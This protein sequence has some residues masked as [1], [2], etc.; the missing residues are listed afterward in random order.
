M[1][2]HNSQSFSAQVV[3]ERGTAEAA[4]AVAEVFRR[5]GFETGAFVA[6]NFSITAPPELF[7]AYFGVSVRETPS[8]LPLEPL[9]EL[10]KPLVRAIGFPRGYRS[11]VN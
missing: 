7:E 8:S 3:L 9:P 11:T 5:A 2:T 10:I 4:S 1:T 6:N